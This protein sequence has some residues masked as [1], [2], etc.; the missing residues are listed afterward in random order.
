[1]GWH[2]MACGGMGWQTPPLGKRIPV[3]A[4]PGHLSTIEN[5]RI[6]ATNVDINLHLNENIL[7]ITT[8][9]LNRKETC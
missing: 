1:M 5:M 6:S 8:I 3:F 4:T 7:M 9:K 2:G